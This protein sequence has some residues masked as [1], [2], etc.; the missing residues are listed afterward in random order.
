MDVP[1]VVTASSTPTLEATPTAVFS[2][3]AVPTKE[4][5]PG[6]ATPAPTKSNPLCGSVV[7]I[8]LALFWFARRKGNH[9]L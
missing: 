6:P 4:V 2:G 8:P 3:T 5:A 9:L 7:L 1:S